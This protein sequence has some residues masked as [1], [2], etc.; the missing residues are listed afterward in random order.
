[1]QIKKFNLALGCMTVW[2]Y[3]QTAQALTTMP[4]S[5]IKNITI[6]QGKA[7]VERELTAAGGGEQQLV[8]TCLSGNIDQNSIQVFAPAGVNIGET[9]VQTLS[10]EQAKLC[11]RQG[12]QNL[13]QTQDSLD[14]INAKITAQEAS[15]AYLQNFGKTTQLNNTGN[16]KDAANQI[17][18]TAEQTVLNLASLRQQKAQLE[19]QLASDMNA[20]TSVAN[21]VTQ[22]SVRLASRSPASVTLNYIV[23]GASWQPQYQASLDTTRKKLNLDLQAVVAQTTGE[24]WQNVPLTLSTAE[25][26]YYTSVD[27]PTPNRLRMYEPRPPVSPMARAEYLEVAPA[28]VVVVDNMENEQSVPLPSYQASSNQKGDLVEYRLPQRVTIPSDGRRITTLLDSQSAAAEVWVRTIPNNN[29]KAYWYA[30]APSLNKNWVNGDIRLYR[31]NNYIGNGQFDTEVMT[32]KGLGFGINNQILVT[33][34]QNSNKSD[35]KGMFGGSQNKTQQYSYRITNQMSQPINVEVLS[36]IPISED[37]KITVKSA[38]QPPVTTE[39]WQDKTGVVAWQ[40]SLSPNQSQVVSESH[41]ITYP[42]DKQLQ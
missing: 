41:E 29:Q 31:D 22:V 13:G 5:T 42:K 23:N 33:E 6:Y 25:P 14:S 10:G 35:T 24:N 26:S 3:S 30:K 38:Y 1:M 36:G 21:R 11:Q 8:F 27:D 16:I 7:S 34:L 15:L 18:Q 17:A 39:K 20:S 9:N 19:S 40:F 2:C 12:N 4:T 28:P 37:G 32:Q